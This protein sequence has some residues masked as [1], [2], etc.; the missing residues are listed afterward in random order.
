MDT[1]QYLKDVG[2]PIQFWYVLTIV[3][4]GIMSLLIT[5]L[6]YLV[7]R[8][9]ERMEITLGRLTDM[10]NLHEV[11]INILKASRSVRKR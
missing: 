1:L 4:F 9:F 3:S 11:E 2:A 10:V 8:V 5:F 7:K 6:I